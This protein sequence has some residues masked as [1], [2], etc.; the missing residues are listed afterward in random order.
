MERWCRRGVGFKERTIA[1]AGVPR[2]RVVGCPTVL[3]SLG[4]R[5][6]IYLSLTRLH[7]PYSFRSQT[8]TASLF[9]PM[10]SLPTVDAVLSS[11]LNRA[12]TCLYHSICMLLPTNPLSPCAL[13]PFRIRRFKRFSLRLRALVCR[14]L[15]AP[16]QDPC[17][18]LSIRLLR[19]TVCESTCRV[20]R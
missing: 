7:L 20:R 4:N 10:K 18:K 9:Y 8:S 1:L 17:T 14:M 2:A 12:P 3:V 5:P 11:V 16:L 13:L 6:R 19:F 15:F